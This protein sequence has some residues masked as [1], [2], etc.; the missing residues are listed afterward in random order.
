[1][2]IGERAL[3]NGLRDVED[4]CGTLGELRGHCCNDAWAVMPKDG[5]DRA[6]LVCLVCGGHG[7]SL[8]EAN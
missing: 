4:V 5:D 7:S 2:V 8:V 3:E 1:M 6:V